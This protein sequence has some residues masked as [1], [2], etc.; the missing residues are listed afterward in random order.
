MTG[1]DGLDLAQDFLPTATPDLFG[2]ERCRE[3]VNTRQAVDAMKETLLAGF[4]PE[5]DAPRTRVATDTGEMLQMPSTFG[6]YV[7]TKILTLT[8][9]NVVEELPMIQ[10]VYVLFAGRQQNPVAVLDGA[11]LTNIRTPA[12]SAFGA[13]HLVTKTG[14]L[15]LT[16]VG[17]GVQAWEHVLALTSV[18]DIGEIHIVGRDPGNVQE[19]VEQGCSR[20]FSVQASD[21]ADALPVSDVV[22]SCT[23]AKEPPFDGALVPDHAVVV[24]VGS[25]SPERRELDDGL[26]ARSGIAVESLDSSTREAGEI[27]QGLD[28]GAIPDRSGLVTMRQLAEGHTLP[29]GQ[30][31]IFKTTGMPW[32]D[33]AVASAIYEGAAAKMRLSSNQRTDRT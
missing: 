15:T 13:L 16:I 2:P 27:I 33:L 7:G 21:A 19:L 32:Q 1:S 9:G 8:P 26:L 20:G 12:V 24:A 23:S 17:T 6:D 5:H 18:L 28:S 31:K 10:G 11:T 14:P 29:E 3:L 25:H 4:D 30:P 22:V